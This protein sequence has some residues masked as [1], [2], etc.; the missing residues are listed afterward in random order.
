MRTGD[1]AR[2][3]P[4]SR[5]SEVAKA[6]TPHCFLAARWLMLDECFPRLQDQVHWKLRSVNAEGGVT[7]EP[8]EPE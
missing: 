7:V 2:S 8:E 3:E 6:D 1:L 5:R 4:Y